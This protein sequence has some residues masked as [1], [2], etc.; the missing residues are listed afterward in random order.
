VTW[1]LRRRARTLSG[2]VSIVALGVIAGW[3]LL[4]A[5][6]FDLVVSSRVHQQLDDAVRIRAQAAS[7]TVRLHHGVISGVGESATDSELDST[8]WV[9]AGTKA[10]HRAE[11]PPGA[12]RVA[13]HVAASGAAFGDG[14]ERRFYV[15]PIESGGH[16]AGSV[17]A[18]ISTEPYDETEKTAVVG[19][20]VVA[21]LLLAGAYPVL[22]LAAA[23]ALRPV[24]EMTRQAADWSVTA[25]MQ[26]FGAEQQY[27][28]VS[29]LARTLD[30]LLDRLAAVLRHERRLSAELSHELR[31]PLA[32]VMTE[33]ELMMAG[34]PP[35]Q[36]TALQSIHD[37]CASMNGIIDTLLV[38]ARTELVRTLGHA[39]LNPVLQSF[40]SD[41]SPAVVVTDTELSVGVDGDVVTRILAP[42]VD[43]GRRFARTEVR[44]GAAHADGAGAVAIRITNDGPVLPSE[45]AEQVF[46]PGFTA[47]DGNGHVGAGLGLALARRLARAADGDL[48]VDIDAPATT[49]VLTLPAG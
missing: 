33:V 16:R 45:L 25:P 40:R 17:V 8:I 4:L 38:T 21:V 22:R 3:L 11:A 15:L 48:A 24:A 42:L 27:R 18:A 30:E 47:S 7:A 36:R 6:G 1:T 2:R 41:A 31:T 10:I 34:A 29:S 14:A 9:Y 43:N 28:E 5:A 39:R 13:D 19:S 35:D 37:N 32:R 49:F 23:R 20:I 26:R 44:L 12:Q 46:E